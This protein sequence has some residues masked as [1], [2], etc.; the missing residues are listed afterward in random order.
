MPANKALWQADLPANGLSVASETLER[1]S[2]LRPVRPWL[3][4][5]QDLASPVPE[6]LRARAPPLGARCPSWGHGESGRAPRELGTG[7]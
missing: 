5:S 1:G 6:P 4:H 7:L 2:V 3:C